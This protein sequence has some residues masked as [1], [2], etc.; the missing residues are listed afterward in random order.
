[1]TESFSKSQALRYTEKHLEKEY[2]KKR[3]EFE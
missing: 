3:I 1:M 2:Y